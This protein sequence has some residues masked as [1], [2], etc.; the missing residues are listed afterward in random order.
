MPAE[1][2]D[3]SSRRRFVRRAGR[4][5][6]RLAAVA[7][8]VQAVVFAVVFT[9]V[10]TTGLV[11]ASGAGGQAATEI[12]LA[13]GGPV[14]TPEA[15]RDAARAAAR[16]AEKPV[17]IVVADG[18][19]RLTAPLALTADDSATEWVAAE[20]ARPV[21]SGG[22]PVTVRRA[23]W[24]RVERRESSRALV[25]GEARAMDQLALACGAL[26]EAPSQ[27]AAAD[28]CAP[29]RDARLKSASGAMNRSAP[30]LMMRPSGSV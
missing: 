7:R 10:Y 2:R 19:Y 3:D 17:R 11:V 28:V 22:E 27:L 29:R 24:A 21:F 20:N 18:T 5:A 25:R 26:S 1:P 15:A 9:V 6:G 14:A 4:N 30:T 16:R 13:P 8:A 12:V 23:A